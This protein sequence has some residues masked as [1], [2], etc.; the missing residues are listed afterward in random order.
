M[1]KEEALNSWH[2]FTKVTSSGVAVI[3]P[4]GQTSKSVLVF[5]H[6]NGGIFH[7][8]PHHEDR[9]S[10]KAKYGE[11]QGRISL[12]ISGGDCTYIF[13]PDDD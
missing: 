3:L 12:L 6:Q 9:L 2:N 10:F 8:T 13:V 5:G 1:V 4:N 7:Q 11:V